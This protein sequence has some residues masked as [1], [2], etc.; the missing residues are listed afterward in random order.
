MPPNARH[1]IRK[2]TDEK[3]VLPPEKTPVYLRFIWLKAQGTRV[4]HF[5]Q[6]NEAQ[7]IVWDSDRLGDTGSFYAAWQKCIR[8]S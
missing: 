5:K 7:I 6:R 2:Q 1:Q 4:G 8:D 3:V